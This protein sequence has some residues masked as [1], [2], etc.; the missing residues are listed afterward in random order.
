MPARIWAIPPNQRAAGNAIAAP[1]LITLA[2]DRLS[3]NVVNAKA[4]S[5]RGAGSATWLTSGAPTR[6]VSPT[7]SLSAM[8]FPLPPL[9]GFLWGN[10]SARYH[11]LPGLDTLPTPRI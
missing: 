6:M 9:M 8:T 3:M 1:A 7:Y 11:P 4:P 2:F 5:P 10:A